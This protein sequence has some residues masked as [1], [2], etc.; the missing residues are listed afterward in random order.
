MYEYIQY[1][2]AF[3]TQ[4]HTVGILLRKVRF[5]GVRL[6]SQAFTVDT[7]IALFSSHNIYRGA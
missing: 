1:I 2:L 4:I 6:G 3:D 5:S 7:Y